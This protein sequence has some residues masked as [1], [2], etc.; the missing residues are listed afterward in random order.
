[1]DGEET[2]I[3]LDDW[4]REYRI[5]SELKK[6]RFFNNYRMWKNFILW[7][8][9][10]R[11]TNFKRK[12]NFLEANLILTDARLSQPLLN[13][14]NRTFMMQTE[15]NLLN[16]TF[17]S[18]KLINEF[19]KHENTNIVKQTALMELMV[20]ENIK[21]I[22]QTSCVQ[23]MNAFLE[24]N[25]IKNPDVDESNANEDEKKMLIVSII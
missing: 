11:S 14:R 17:T 13:I 23:S 15:M 20:N 7:R 9:L 5:Y 12:K 10:R 21:K 19:K 4:E 16:M 3:S 25:R 1:M 18:A 6:I 8:K 2:F 22:L 24:E